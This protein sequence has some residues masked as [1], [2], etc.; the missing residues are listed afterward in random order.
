MIRI[1]ENIAVRAKKK[2]VDVCMATER[3]VRRNLN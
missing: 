2:I 1:H 3:E